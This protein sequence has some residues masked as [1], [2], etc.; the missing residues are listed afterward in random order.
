MAA[1]HPAELM[2]T[3]ISNGRHQDQFPP[4][5]LCARYGFGQETLA[6]KLGNGREAPIAAGGQLATIET[7]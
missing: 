4:S 1:S 2:P 6:G 5:T 7:A 3:G